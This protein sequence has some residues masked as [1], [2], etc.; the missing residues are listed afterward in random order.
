MKSRN[1]IGLSG[2]FLAG[3]M[4]MGLAM[5]APEAANSVTDNSAYAGRRIDHVTPVWRS[6]ER[7]EFAAMETH[8]SMP[9]SEPAYSGRRADHILQLLNNRKGERSEF[10]A[11]EGRAVSQGVNSH[12]EIAYGGRRVDHLDLYR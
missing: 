10:A 9:I 1:L 11:L 12:S 8:A 3:S 2:L 4:A 5:G 6:V 7:A